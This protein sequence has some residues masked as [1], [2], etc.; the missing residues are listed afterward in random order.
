MFLIA[1]IVGVAYHVLVNRSRF[2]YDLRASGMNP[3]AARAGGVPPKKMILYSMLASG[4]VAGLIGMP[5]ILSVNHSY[6]QGFVQ[7]LGFAG[8]AVALLGRNSAP[9][10]A[11]S[12]LLF[13]FLDTSSAPLQVSGTASPEIV[14]I[15]MATIL[16][17]AVIAYEVVNR[18]RQADEVR[19]AALATEA[20]TAA[21]IGVGA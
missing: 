8:I 9:G 14:V 10:M 18:V 6:D 11:V 3:T 13:A 5:E 7:G 17:T 12:A 21:E 16:L 19:R 2:G 20:A 15:M 4:A 1:I